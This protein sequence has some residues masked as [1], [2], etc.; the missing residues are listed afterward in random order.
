[1][2]FPDT[3]PTYAN[4]DCDTS[5]KPKDV[6][7]TIQ[8]DLEAVVT[9]VGIDGSSDPTSLDYLAKNAE[10]P[11]HTHT[12][13]TG[14]TDISASPNDL[15]ATTNFEE[16]I[17]ATTSEITI[18]TGKTFNIADDSGLKLNGIA[19]TSTATELNYNDGSTAGTSVASKTAV[20]GADKNLDLLSIDNA[21][22]FNA[23]EGFMINGKISASVTSNNLTVALKTLAGNDPSTSDP[24]YV[25]ISDT[26]R[27]ITSALSI[28]LNA[29]TN[30][31]DCG[32]IFSNAA[33]VNLFIFLGYRT[34]NTSVF[35]ALG[36]APS[37]TTYGQYSSTTTTPLYMPT[38]GSAPAS[39]DVIVNTGRIAV[40]L[41]GT[42]N[43]NWSIPAGAQTINRPIFESEMLTWNSTAFTAESG[44][45]AP[46]FTSQWYRWWKVVGSNQ[47]IG[48]T[49]FN[50]TG[51]TVGAG[52]GQIYI[53][54]IPFLLPATI[55]DAS[56]SDAILGFGSV[57]NTTYSNLVMVRKIGP[58]GDT[59]SLR[60]IRFM[61][62]GGGGV[63][64]ANVDQTAR[65]I[66]FEAI[67]PIF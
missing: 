62:V 29:G 48:M 24:I 25:R 14:A 23:I 42:P 63:T 22:K 43:F 65:A 2:A 55:A 50:S 38:T 52:A 26:V 64:G 33:K 32:S 8:D 57:D 35:L 30:W 36:K 7:N 13:E 59:S 39:T 19:V 41:S 46:D 40:Q 5:A 1:M 3:L 6:V 21:I 54:Y 66:A 51:G 4:I 9:K 18:K 45:T 27:S 10:D 12:L 61:K 56:R 34:S 67:I 53:D 31:F 47:Q 16:T 60:S 15:N 37:G 28:T 17:S 20:L 49:A 44:S 58:S 11:G